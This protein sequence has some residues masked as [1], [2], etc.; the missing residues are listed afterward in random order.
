VLAVSRRAGPLAKTNLSG[1][2]QHYHCRYPHL[3]RV[4]CKPDSQCVEPRT[5][6]PACSPGQEPR[7]FPSFGSYRERIALKDIPFASSEQML[8]DSYR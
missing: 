3:S 4:N 7:R 2:L 8:C 1:K 6:H 5:P